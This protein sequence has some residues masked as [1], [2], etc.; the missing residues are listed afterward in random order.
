MKILLT[1][2]WARNEDIAIL[3]KFPEVLQ[4]DTTFKTNKEGRPLFNIVCKVSNNK[5]TTVFR[6][7]LPSKKRSIFHSILSSVMPKVLGQETCMR[8]KFIITD[9]D[10]QEIQAC[11]SAIYNVFKNAHH[12]TCLWHLIHQSISK[13]K[14]I[15]HPKLKEILRNW[16]Y[17][18][19]TNIES[20]IELSKCLSHLKVYII[21]CY[22][23]Y[24][25][26]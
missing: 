25:L 20:D 12:M 2:G 9:G 15:Q 22:N 3:R 1:V 23:L 5:L 21:Y 11:Q 24:A 16:L 7:L 14:V 19:A 26:K 13:T 17:F 18:T 4:M 10:S 6:C 8:V